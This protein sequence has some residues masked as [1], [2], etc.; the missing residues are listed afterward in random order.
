MVVSIVGVVYRSTDVGIFL[1]VNGRRV[2]V[3]ADCMVS[4]SR[5]YE[6][7]RSYALRS[8]NSSRGAG[9]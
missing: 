4:P 7:V 8:T 3:P 2:L 1:D 5:K 9:A 6:T